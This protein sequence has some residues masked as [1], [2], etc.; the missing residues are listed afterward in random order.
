MFNRFSILILLFILSFFSACSS[1]SENVKSFSKTITK[2]SRISSNLISIDIPEGWRNIDDNYKKIF[3]IWLVNDEASAAIG[4]IPINT[5]S[6]F[7]VLSPKDKLEFIE[8]IVITKNKINSEEFK[9]INTKKNLEDRIKIEDR[10]SLNGK[11]QNLI[12]FNKEEKYFES[13]AYFTKNYTPTD[14]EQSQLFKLQ[15]KI[16]SNLRIN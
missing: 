8:K 15:R 7:L 13:I 4:F 1:S 6:T 9:L 14:D 10:I 2:P 11:T 3:D 12:I 16:I 5:D